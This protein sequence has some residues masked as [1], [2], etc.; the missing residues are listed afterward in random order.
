MKHHAH[1]AVRCRTPDCATVI[2]L[3]NGYIGA[4]PPE[5]E[6][7]KPEVEPPDWSDIP[8]PQCHTTLRYTSDDFVVRTLP[9]QFEPDGNV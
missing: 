9:Y 5:Q 4:V 8:C 6:S 3:K 1:W 7:V 2:F